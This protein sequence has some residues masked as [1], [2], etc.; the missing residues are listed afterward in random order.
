MPGDGAGAQVQRHAV[1]LLVVQG[2]FDALAGVHGSGQWLGS[3]GRWVRW[4]MPS[5]ASMAGIVKLAM[6]LQRADGAYVNLQPC[7]GRLP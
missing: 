1:R 5:L 6:P 7:A 3:V 4:V 2:R